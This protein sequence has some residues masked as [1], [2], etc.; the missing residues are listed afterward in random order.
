[1]EVTHHPN[2]LRSNSYLAC[3]PYLSLFILPLWPVLSD[4]VGKSLPFVILIPI[5]VVFA[6]TYGFRCGVILTLLFNIPAF[7]HLNNISNMSE[8]AIV[9]AGFTAEGIF[10]SYFAD[11]FR[12]L[13]HE[14]AR[15]AIAIA[16][17]KVKRRDVRLAE[18]EDA[19]KR[20]ERLFYL[21]F[22]AAPSG[23]IIV[24]Q[25]GIIKYVN[26]ETERI[27]GY[28]RDELLGRDV[29]ILIPEKSR[30][31]HRAYRKKFRHEEPYPRR[32]G[33]GRR[34]YG[35]RKDKVEVPIEAGLSP[36]RQNGEFLILTSIIELTEQEKL[37]REAQLR[38]QAEEAA[39][40][41]DEFLSILSHELRT[42]LNVILGWVRLLKRRKSNLQ[43][44]ER[45]LKAIEEGARAQAYLI[46]DLLDISRISSGKL[47]L[48][49][50]D[51]D[52][53]SV[54]VA[55]IDTVFPPMKEKKL[56]LEKS[57]AEKIPRIK[58]DPGRLQQ[59][60]WN[61]LTNSIKF[62]P[63]NGT[64]RINLRCVKDRIELAISDTG[65][66]IEK[67]FLPV[68]FERFRQANSS[69]TRMYGGLGLGLA[70]VRHLV[71]LHGGTITAASAGKNCGSTFTI[72]L[73]VTHTCYETPALSGASQKGNMVL[74]G[75]CRILVVEDDLQSRELLRNLLEDAG[76]TVVSVGSV[77]EA[78]LAIQ[79][80]IPDVIISDIAMPIKSGFDLIKSL[81][82]S[83]QSENRTIP[84]IALTAFAE[85]K[86]R[87]DAL[88]AGFQ[89]H[90]AKPID[91]ALLLKIISDLL[92]APASS[93]RN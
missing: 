70:I 43:E 38:M 46:S 23:Y 79:E 31:A 91:E 73:P 57:I 39:R 66:G 12:S 93:K 72:S 13:S 16:D 75:R 86:D 48:E 65:Q 20:F 5:I 56:V 76:A 29:E 59:C 55:A 6:C 41:K 32:L 36:L 81:R 2:D 69:N 22:E 8:S 11:R 63:P 40:V 54:L 14:L 37:E 15:D 1:M 19:K 87:L 80:R 88:S 67:D 84:A 35:L 4:I 21:A 58:G 28:N 45:G 9:L 7:F 71:E 52:L 51:V 25:E 18:A 77:D 89:A 26:Y 85:E 24:D 61:I 74:L 47:R 78:L 50:T 90:L 68:I 10:L 83:A 62:T 34:L 64:I 17:A 30:N 33:V 44:L 3:C 92:G 42:P 53:G 82:A 49:I 60:I 27:F